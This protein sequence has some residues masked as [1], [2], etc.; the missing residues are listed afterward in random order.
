M[1][2]KAFRRDFERLGPQCL[3]ADLSSQAHDT[4]QYSDIHRLRRV[5]NR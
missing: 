2:S 3:A 1:K 5:V 4:F